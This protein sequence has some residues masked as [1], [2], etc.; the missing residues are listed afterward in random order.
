MQVFYTVRFGDTISSIAKRFNIPIISLINANN[1]KAPYK[2]YIGQQLSMPPGVTT[3]VV[4]PGDS[5]YAIS[6][7]YGIPIRIILKANT[8]EEPY[9]IMPG[10]IL[11][12][13]QGVPFYVVN[14][15]DSL[16]KIAARYNVIVNGQPSAELIIKANPGL[17]ASIRPG[18]TISIPYPPPGGKGRLAAVLSDDIN[19]YL[20]FYDTTT[21]QRDTMLLDEGS[22]TSRIF[23]APNRSKIAHI[24]SSGVISI[25]DVPTKRVSKVDKIPVPGFI[26]WSSDSQTIVYSNG[27]LIRMYNVTNYTSTTIYRVGTSYVQWFPNSN[28]LL[29]EAKDSSNTSQLYKNSLDGSNEIQITKNANGNLNE[30]RLSPNGNYV[31]YTT[32]GVSISEIYTIELATGNIYKIPGGPEAKNYYPI[33]SPDSTKI[34]YS[35]TQ[36]INGKY[37]SLIR[38]T[39]LKGEA[40]STIAIG[41]C[42]A[43][44]LAW[45][46]DSRKIAYLSGCRQEYKPVEV[47]SIDID[48]L[49]PINILS[50]F[51]FYSIDW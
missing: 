4:K 29:Y 21:G 25:I 44:P 6:T 40:D 2:I 51:T 28:E 8:I 18:M 22:E 31:L 12:I 41:S 13:P 15:G 30:V 43:T 42:F 34:A 23:W 45:S 47:W 7:R 38:V 35:S 10:Q 46:P 20:M 50:G 9:T 5:I 37:Y 33:W 19:S 16:Y 24:G 26:D 27:K 17:T 36:F 39:G 3:Y 11:N 49:V 48:K 32:P 1:L 14:P